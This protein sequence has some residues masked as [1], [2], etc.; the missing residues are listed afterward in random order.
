[1]K[2]FWPIAP[3]S[4]INTDLFYASSVDKSMHCQP[5]YYDQF[6]KKH[7]LRI[8]KGRRTRVST[9]PYSATG[10]QQS[11]AHNPLFYLQEVPCG[12]IH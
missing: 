3:C 2:Q 12:L 9:P 1:M 4:Q 10:L 11:S 7:V 8:P 6:L 5:R